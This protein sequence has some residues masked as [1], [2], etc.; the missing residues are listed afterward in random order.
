[1]RILAKSIHLGSALLFAFLL[2]GCKSMPMPPATKPGSVVPPAVH[3]TDTARSAPTVPANVQRALMPALPREIPKP[4]SEEEQR[5][6]IAIAEPIEIREFLMSLVED[7]PYNM[8]VHP[9]VTG[10]LTLTLKDVTIRDVLAAVRS[11]YGFEYTDS[12]QGFTVYPVQ[13]QTQI[14]NVDYVN[15][16]RSGT[17]LIR[18]SAGQ[19]TSSGSDGSSSETVGSSITTATSS[20]F[21]TNLARKI[22]MIIGIE[23]GRSVTADPEASVLIVRA[24]PA[25]LR[26]V[27]EFLDR[28]HANMHRQVIL[29]AKVLEVELNDDFQAGVDWDV[30]LGGSRTVGENGGG[31]LSSVLSTALPGDIAT[32]PGAGLFFFETDAISNSFAATIDFLESQ[33]DVEILSSPRVATVSNQKAVIKV[34]TDEFF[35]TGLSNTNVTGT[36]TTNSSSVELEPF[37]SGISLDVTPQIA[38]DGQIVLH[39]HPSVS[40]VSEIIKNLPIGD[41]NSSEAFPLA[42][43][44]IRESDS[45]VRARSGDMVVIGGLM[46]TVTREEHAGIPILSDIPYIGAAFRHTRKKAR[47][48]ELVILLRPH[49]VDDTMT[50]Q[51][52]APRLSDR[53]AALETYVPGESSGTVQGAVQT[54]P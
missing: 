35:V 50:T 6:D 11:V 45:I 48:T 1:M 9:E 21:W 24:Q 5:F 12:G 25:E 29:E 4:S 46:D 23:G 52:L 22:E 15:V 10:T 38:E 16:Q 54:T 43:S 51:K 2:G 39:I 3:R 18:V 19:V 42:K 33:G 36:N 34:G 49:I 20:Q 26:K 32:I 41:D 8:L 27:E 14:F 17:S 47:K 37:F 40:V 28:A 13:M 31:F 30:F 53:L 7:T 44:T